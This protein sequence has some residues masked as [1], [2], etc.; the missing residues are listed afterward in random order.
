[1]K[2]LAIRMPVVGGLD[3]SAGVRCFA[4]MAFLRRA[5]R[6]TQPSYLPLLGGKAVWRVLDSATMQNLHRCILRSGLCLL[7]IGSRRLGGVL[8]GAGALW[9]IARNET[10]YCT[11]FQRSLCDPTYDETF[12][13]I[14]HYVQHC[15]V[16]YSGACSADLQ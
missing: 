2:R 7:G 10:T 15:P 14:C 6:T 8:F 4:Y 16:E 13:D 5:W 9:R 12:P 1:M 3:A 11:A